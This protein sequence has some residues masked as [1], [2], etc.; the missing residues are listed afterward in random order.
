MAPIS[1]SASTL[2]SVSFQPTQGPDSG[3][4]AE[5]VPAERRRAPLGFGF[6]D[7]APTSGPFAPAG[8]QM[9]SGWSISVTRR[10]VGKS[11]RAGKRSGKVHWDSSLRDSED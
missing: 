5:L 8:I 9:E 6:F 10:L 2:P 11:S 7:E 4:V 1:R 3:T